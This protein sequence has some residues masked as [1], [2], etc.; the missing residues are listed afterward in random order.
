MNFKG[1]PQRGVVK[2]SRP[3][4]PPLAKLPGNGLAH[5]FRTKVWSIPL[6]STQPRIQLTESP[7]PLIQMWRSERG[8]KRA[9]HEYYEITSSSSPLVQGKGNFPTPSDFRNG[10][11]GHFGY[12]DAIRPQLGIG[13][14]NRVGLICVSCNKHAL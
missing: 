11:T 8:A 4:G 12:N 10:S 13:H 3:W 14:K 7:I 1:H 9:E 5:E 2:A 6:E